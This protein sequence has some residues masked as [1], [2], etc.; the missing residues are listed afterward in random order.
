MAAIVPISEAAR[1]GGYP[2]KVNGQIFR[3]INDNLHRRS[4]SLGRPVCSSLEDC[5]NTALGN[6]PK[7]SR[8]KRSPLLNPLLALPGLGKTL[9]AKTLTSPP[10]VN[11]PLT[12]KTILSILAG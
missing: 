5:L 1:S 8:S 4:L 10:I 12:L 7:I 2:V 11:G 6:N 3:F 9:V